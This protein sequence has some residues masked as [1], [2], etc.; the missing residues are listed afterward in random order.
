M[1]DCVAKIQSVYHGAQGAVV[2]DSDQIRTFFI[3][4]HLKKTSIS[5]V[6]VSLAR[7]SAI[8]DSTCRHL[9]MVLRNYNSALHSVTRVGMPL[10]GMYGLEK[11]RTV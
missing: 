2:N 7:Q 6:L 11:Y 1:L 5:G 8:V 4:P 9:S 10:C 3:Q